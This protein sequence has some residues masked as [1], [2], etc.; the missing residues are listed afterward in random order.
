MD[1]AE[2]YVDSIKVYSDKIKA[3]RQ[4]LSWIPTCEL[5]NIRAMGV[6]D[7]IG[8]KNLYK[9]GDIDVEMIAIEV[10]N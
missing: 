10:E 2:Y 1:K 8:V 5:P 6:S 4:Y 9:C 3:L 7:V